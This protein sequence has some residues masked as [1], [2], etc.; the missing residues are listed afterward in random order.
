MNTLARLAPLSALL[1]VLNVAACSSN[2]HQPSA[3]VEHAPAARA[4]ESSA[5]RSP[6]SAFAAL[7]L[8]LARLE[9]H[10]AAGNV[11]DLGRVK[12]EREIAAAE[13]AERIRLSFDVDVH[14]ANAV[15]ATRVFESLLADL[16][17]T[18]GVIECR[19]SRTTEVGSD[20]RAKGVELV[21]ELP[22]EVRAGADR[23]L[24]GGLDS[25]MRALATDAKLGPVEVTVL[26][27][28][29]SRKDVVEERRSMHT[30]EPGGEHTLA[31]LRALFARL[32]SVEPCASVTALELA[33]NSAVPG[34]WTW[35]VVVTRAV[36]A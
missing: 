10:A 20:V 7:E 21:V 1:A 2:S 13:A 17:R 31:A 33:P 8:L 12:A 19:F 23:G 29:R 4:P 5:R 24:E 36:D 3:A 28:V 16:D 35:N 25:R 22:R 26:H 34:A 6:Q 30:L 18:P 11:L 15:E 9:S 32:D 14:A 27:A